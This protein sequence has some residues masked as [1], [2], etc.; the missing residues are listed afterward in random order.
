MTQSLS[1][2]IIV[3]S[4]IKKQNKQSHFSRHAA[5]VWNLYT[6]SPL[7][8]IPWWICAYGNKYALACDQLIFW[9]IL[10]IF[11]NFPQLLITETKLAWLTI[12]GIVKRVYISLS[13]TPLV[14]IKNLVATESV[15]REAR[16]DC[17]I[18]MPKS[19]PQYWETQ[20]NLPA[21][22]GTEQSVCNL[23]QI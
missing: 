16:L 7:I 18:D 5:F 21:L 19:S 1:T 20:N 14:I 12:K 17:L 4:C 9:R 13:I 23:N 8:P 6:W 3:I 10:N 2:Q 15:K 11:W 22:T